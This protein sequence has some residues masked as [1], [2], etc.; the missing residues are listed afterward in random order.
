VVK[1][2]LR[3]LLS[4]LVGHAGQALPRELV[5]DLLWPDSEPAGAVNSLNQA[6]FQLRRLLDPE[7]KDGVSP[8]YVQSTVELVALDSELVR[9][10]LDEFRRRASALPEGRLIPTASAAALL[11]LVRGEYLAD[12]RYSDWAE[13]LRAR[14]HGEVRAT[15][16]SLLKSL[17][18]DVAIRAAHTLILL[19]EF[20][21]LG[22]VALWEHLAA[23][24][25]RA[26]ARAASE[27]FISKYRH[28][29]GENPSATT[30]DGAARLKTNVN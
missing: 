27:A 4:L 24:G 8:A 25:R 16:S 9:T 12:A 7:Y 13:P 3:L 2:R 18:N 11:D 6:I 21:E 10:D 29:F 23:A 30:M 5:L 17:D 20:D 19:D 22:Q 1:R 15:L 14:V 28:E 26:A